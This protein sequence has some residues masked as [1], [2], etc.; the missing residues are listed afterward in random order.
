[1]NRLKERIRALGKDVPV[2]AKIERPEAVETLDHILHSA[3]G[4]M[5]ARGDLAIEMS[6]EDIPVLQKR[7][8]A[9][10]NRHCRFVITAT[11]MLESM[12]THRIPT[13]AEATDVAN[14]VFDGT[15]AVMLSAET[16][17]GLHPLESVKVMNRIIRRAEGEDISLRDLKPLGAAANWT[18]PEAVCE[19]AATAEKTVKAKAIVALTESGNTARLIS[20]RRPTIPIVAL[21][22]SEGIRRQMA[23]YWGVLP[24][25][26]KPIHDTDQ[27]IQEAEKLI[28]QEGLA[29]TG[30]RLV[31]LTGVQSHDPGGTNI[32]KIHEVGE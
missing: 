18:T 27:R 4:I 25:V 22:P 15:D 14:A 8:I 26:M 31:I 29:D 7:I 3:E 23:L 1:M 20:H 10:A 21:T 19:A 12:T 5:I 6:P 11:Q 24:Y 2:I 30:D 32:M 17:A 16:S 28:K 9:S 13:R